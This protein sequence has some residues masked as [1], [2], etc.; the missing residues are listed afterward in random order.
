[1]PIQ[2]CT[3]F[4]VIGMILIVLVLCLSCVRHNAKVN[5]GPRIFTVNMMLFNAIHAIVSFL[6]DFQSA[7][8]GFR[9]ML[10]DSGFNRIVN[11]AESVRSLAMLVFNCSLIPMMGMSIVACLST[12]RI[13]TRS[14]V[15]T[16]IAL[17]GISDMIPI[18]IQVVN[19]VTRSSY[20]WT[21]GT[22]LYV[23]ATFALYSVQIV[24]TVTALVVLYLKSGKYITPDQP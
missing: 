22:L 17:V 16:F 23:L 7:N 3:P 1:M 24:L 4:D 12:T 11:N 21:W 20:D 10:H 5:V 19:D 15:L 14:S 18:L 8:E 2:I 9:K 13:S 6:T